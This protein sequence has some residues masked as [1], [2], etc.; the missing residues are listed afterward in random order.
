MAT[1]LAFPELFEFESTKWVALISVKPEKCSLFLS[2][3]PPYT[4][5]SF[6]FCSLPKQLPSYSSLHRAVTLWPCCCEDVFP[7]NTLT[8]FVV[9]L[10]LLHCFSSQAFSS[11][12][13]QL[14]YWLC[15]CSSSP[16]TCSRA[17]VSPSAQIPLPL[18][19]WYHLP[20]YLPALTSGFPS[21]AP[22]LEDR[23][24]WNHCVHALSLATYS[25]LFKATTLG[26]DMLNT[27]QI[28]WQVLF[29]QCI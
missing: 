8:A 1:E 16:P 21:S 7:V 24:W 27:I 9:P 17:A 13:R 22:G 29:L 18:R 12:P 11:P 23:F 3:T 6:A 19:P 28:W 20:R 15:S 10:L 5:I 2:H 4:S 25:F 26:S 14:Y